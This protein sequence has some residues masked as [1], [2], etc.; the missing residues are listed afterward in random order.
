VLRL[1]LLVEHK[2]KQHEGYMKRLFSCLHDGNNQCEWEYMKDHKYSRFSTKQFF[3]ILR[4]KNT[5]MEYNSEV[6]SDKFHIKEIYASGDMHS[7]RLLKL[8]FLLAYVHIYIHIN[9]NTPTIS[10]YYF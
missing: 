9:Y 4:I 6:M 8:L 3:C 1:F 10:A 5:I 7:K 2:V